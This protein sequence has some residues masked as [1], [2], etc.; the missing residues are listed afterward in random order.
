MIKITK[1]NE[2]KICE[3]WKNW[4]HDGGRNM[5]KLKEKW[6]RMYLERRKIDVIEKFYRKK[7]GILEMEKIRIPREPTKDI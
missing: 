7:C 2:K 1:T 4:S 6:Q 3:C 5:R